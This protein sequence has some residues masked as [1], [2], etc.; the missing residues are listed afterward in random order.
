MGGLGRPPQKGNMDYTK[1]RLDNQRQRGYPLLNRELQQN[2]PPLYA[3][4]EIGIQAL[5]QVKFFTPDSTWV[6]FASEFDG[7][8][9]FFGMVRGHELELGYFSLSE[10]ESL[11]GPLGLPVE[12]DFWFKPTSLG[13]LKRAYLI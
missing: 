3:N 8:D 10:L 9:T 12:R 7:K 1:L 5:A 6:W 4:E 11:R 13:D 2:L